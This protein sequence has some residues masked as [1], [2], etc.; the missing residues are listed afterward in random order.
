MEHFEARLEVDSQEAVADSSLVSCSVSR[1]EHF[2]GNKAGNILAN[3]RFPD[4]AVAVVG[5]NN[6]RDSEDMFGNALD[7]WVASSRAVEVAHIDR[8]VSVLYRHL[9]EL[10]IKRN[11]KK[12]E[13]ENNE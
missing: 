3:N 8:M 1:K 9:N 7:A 6:R 5:R 2:V 13:N 12:R 11:K 10:T 4:E